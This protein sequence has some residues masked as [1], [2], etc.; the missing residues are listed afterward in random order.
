MIGARWGVEW[1]VMGLD[2]NWA[3]NPACEMARP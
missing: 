1:C 3:H 2:R